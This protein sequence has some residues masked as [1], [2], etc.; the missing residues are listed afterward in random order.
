MNHAM[1]SEYYNE[2]PFNN[3]FSV[4]QNLSLLHLNIRSVPLHFTE[5]LSYL[6]TLNVNFKII[7]LTLSRPHLFRFHENNPTLDVIK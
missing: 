4:N 1:T 3:T 5:C 6:G 2:M 7:A